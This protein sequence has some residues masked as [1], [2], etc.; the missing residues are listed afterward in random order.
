MGRPNRH[1]WNRVRIRHKAD[2]SH[3]NVSDLTVRM[4]KAGAHHG[5]EG[6]FVMRKRTAALNQKIIR[7]KTAEV[8]DYTHDRL[9][10]KSHNL[11]EFPNACLPLLPIQFAPSSVQGGQAR[12]AGLTPRGDCTGANAPPDAVTSKPN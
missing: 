3:R 11:P 2:S 1:A 12:C 6:A 8:T 5:V 9:V 7:E 4:R 10:T